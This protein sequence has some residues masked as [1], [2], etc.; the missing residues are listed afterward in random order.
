MHGKTGID[1]NNCNRKQSLGITR[2]TSIKTGQVV[3][4]GYQRYRDGEIWST[5]ER[6]SEI[7]EQIVGMD[8]YWEGS[9]EGHVSARK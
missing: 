2:K 6:C 5:M 9:K 1:Y 3:V 8:A 7:Q 4:C